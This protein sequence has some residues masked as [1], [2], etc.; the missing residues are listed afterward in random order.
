MRTRPIAA[1]GLCL[2]LLLCGCGGSE[3]RAPEDSETTSPAPAPAGST[4]AEPTPPPIGDVRVSIVPLAPPGIEG[5]DLAREYTRMFYAGELDALFEKFSPEMREQI[6]PL[7]KLRALREQMLGQYGEEV[8][9]LGEDAQTKGEYRGFARFARFSKN[10]AV[11][12]LRWILRP[13]DSVAGFQVMPA[14]KP[15]PK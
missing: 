7:D 1:C 5:A 8:Q 4:A 2:A 15:Q 10:D 6:L 13:D 14:R 3:P 9:L 11:L 12:Q